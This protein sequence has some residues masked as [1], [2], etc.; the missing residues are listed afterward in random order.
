MDLADR[1]Y[2][3]TQ[4]VT[5]EASPAKIRE[6]IGTLREALEYG[7]KSIKETMKAIDEELKLKENHNKQICNS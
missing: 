1:Y 5:E 7:S 6:V 4:Y 3:S 2:Y